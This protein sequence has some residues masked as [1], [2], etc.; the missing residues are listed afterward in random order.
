MSHIDVLHTLDMDAG[1]YLRLVPVAFLN[2]LN[3]F[4]V[5]E[6]QPPFSSGK[7]ESVSTALQSIDS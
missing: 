6:F 4:L 5:S 3:I 2:V 1:Q 7:G